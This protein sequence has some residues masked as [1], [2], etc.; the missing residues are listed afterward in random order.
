MSHQLFVESRLHP[1]AYC[2]AN[3]IGRLARRIDVYACAVPALAF[4]KCD[5][6][7]AVMSAV[8]NCARRRE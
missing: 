1:D 5:V 6:L 2:H 8:V 4:G 3:A 7:I